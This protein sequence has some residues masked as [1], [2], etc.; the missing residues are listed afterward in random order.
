MFIPAFRTAA[1][2][3]PSGKPS[4]TGETTVTP[5]AFNI[6]WS[7]IYMRNDNAQTAVRADSS[8]TK[9]RADINAGEFRIVLDKTF[10]NIKSGDIILLPPS[11][12]F[13]DDSRY[14]ITRLLPLHDIFGRLHHFEIDL[15]KCKDPLP[16]ET[17][18]VKNASGVIVNFK[19]V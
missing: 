3:S 10:V 11:Q 18:A 12:T 19:A 7:P 9:S 15:D 5:K 8:A 1:V 4:L 6:G 14:K 2:F 17:Y 13:N 16:I